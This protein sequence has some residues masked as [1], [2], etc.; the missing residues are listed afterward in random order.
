M[1]MAM[2]AKDAVILYTPAKWARA[3]MVPGAVTVCRCG[4]T[5]R[6]WDEHAFKVGA[7]F[8]E[9]RKEE[10]VKALA[11]VLL[12]FQTMVVRDGI[13]PQVAHKALMQ[14]DEYASAMAPE[15]ADH[16]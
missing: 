8:T 12:T 2:K 4:E 6:A 9:V 14:I 3:G 7:A 16:D 11:R 5:G 15:L 10:G 13:D 1:E